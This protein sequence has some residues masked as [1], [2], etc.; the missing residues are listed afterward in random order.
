[1]DSAEEPAPIGKLLD[2]GAGGGVSLSSSSPPFQQ[3]YSVHA[4]AGALRSA[5]Q[6]NELEITCRQAHASVRLNGV[7]INLIEGLAII[8]NTTDGG[9][10]RSQHVGLQGEGGLVDFRRIR[11]RDLGGASGSGLASGSR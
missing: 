6:W 4:I 1:M 10:T 3:A 7:V 8:S 2:Y 11:I 9:T 5:G